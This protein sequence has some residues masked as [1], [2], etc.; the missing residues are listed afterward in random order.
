MA[1][2]ASS[3]QKTNSQPVSVPEPLPEPDLDN[4]LSSIP[5]LKELFGSGEKS[6]ETSPERKEPAPESAEADVPVEGIAAG[7]EAVEPLKEEVETPE[8]E[9]EKPDAVQKRID[10][11]TAQR[12]SAEE[13]AQALEAELSDLKA[14]F[15]APAPVTPSPQDPLANVES[16]QEL[17]RRLDLSRTAKSWAIQHLDGGEV[18]LGDGK[19]QFLDGT[20]VKTLLARAE[21]MLSV[22]IPRRQ[23]Y[24]AQKRDFDSQAKR[25]YPSL[26]K[27]GTND[28]TEFTT[29][30]NVFPECRRYPDIALI[31]GD[32]IMGRAIRLRKAAKSNGQATPHPL[33]APAPAAQPR[34]PKSR[35]L[36]GAELQAIATDPQGPA[37]DRFVSQLIDEAD[38]QRSKR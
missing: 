38:T 8:P 29:W 28:H 37:L 21:D 14:K 22:H 17:G 5:D 23:Q 33:A 30:L 25:I 3:S 35:A 26:F 20:Q 24:L 34:V 6:G 9:P 18:D 7:L 13:K 15:A 11:L 10:K 27:P 4:L 31:V 36:S 32:A 12:K 16:E 1:E 19:T 2:E